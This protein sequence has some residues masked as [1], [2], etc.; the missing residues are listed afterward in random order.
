MRDEEGERAK[1][2]SCEGRFLDAKNAGA[3]LDPFSALVIMRLCK[4]HLTMRMIAM[5]A[6]S[7]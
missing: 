3:E 4:C 2:M 1:S 5:S 6:E 7:L